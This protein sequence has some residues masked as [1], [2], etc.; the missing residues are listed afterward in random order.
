MS[1]V[2]EI[3]TLKEAL[4]RE[5]QARQEAEA[6]LAAA[7]HARQ[8]FVSLVT[9]ELRVPMTSIKGYTDLLLKGIVGPVSD[10]QKNFL[11]TIRANVER[12]SRM[13]AD[14]SDINKLEAGAVKFAPS[15]VA[16]NEALDEALRGLTTAIAE[17]RQTLARDIPDTLPALWC[18]RARLVQ[19]LANLLSNAHLYTPEGGVITVAAEDTSGATAGVQI[20]VRDTGVGILPEEQEHIFEAF[21]RASDEET[22]QIPG[23]G[24]ALRL[25]K[26]LIEQQNGRIWFASERGRGT[27]FHI[28]L[29]I[30]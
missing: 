27:T 15:A 19:V 14:L 29:P 11:Q 17:K 22:R 21:F 25:S 28:Q 6:A 18:D 2:D 5:Q 9:H 7:Q 8:Q 13:V 3:N 10:A 20:A 30:A 26:L 4:A 16:L 23:N 1:A 12:M 24:L